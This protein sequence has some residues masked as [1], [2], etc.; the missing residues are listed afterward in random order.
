M[1]A[2]KENPPLRELDLSNNK[3]S[4]KGVEHLVDSLRMNRN[5]FSLSLLGNR[6]TD[7]GAVS[8]SLVNLVLCDLSK[9]KI[10]CRS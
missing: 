4:D 8:I 5:I 7:S 10:N 9:Y 2:L 6:I 3:I 1:E